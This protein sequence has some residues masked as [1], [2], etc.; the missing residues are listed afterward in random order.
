[1]CTDCKDHSCKGF[2]FSGKS[3]GLLLIRLAVAAI[4]I[5]HGWSKFM[6]MDDTIIFFG[7]L[8]LAPFFAYLVAIVEFIGGIL[9]LLGV[10][11]CTA[12]ISLAVV[13]AFAICLVKAKMG[14][15]ASEPD[16]LLL[17][18]SLALAFTGPGRYSLMK[19]CHCKWCSWM[20]K[21]CEGCAQCDTCAGGMC[22]VSKN[23][24][25]S[26]EKAM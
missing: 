7:T 21:K 22:M 14:F 1:M 5:Y 23:E 8:G 13:I 15:V 6:F 9:M 3:V 4:F 24:S 10:F 11:T 2:H 20:H 16:I 26:A 25:K 12:G 18:S 19:C 17:V